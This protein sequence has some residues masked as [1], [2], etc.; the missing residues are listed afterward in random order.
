[1]EARVKRVY[2]SRDE[3]GPRRIGA[4]E[5]RGG[6]RNEIAFWSDER[7]TYTRVAAKPGLKQIISTF[8]DCPHS[9]IKGLQRR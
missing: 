4:I 9:H 8:I 6:N 7:K 1:V 3:C 2:M 5:Q